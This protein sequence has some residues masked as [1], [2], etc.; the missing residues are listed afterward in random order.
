MANTVFKLRR[1]SVAGKVPNT[2]TVAIGELAINL[3]DKKLFSSDGSL[4]FEIGANLTDLQV[5]NNITTSNINVTD[6][7]LFQNVAVFHD[8]AM[9][10][11]VSANNSNGASGLVLTSN[12]SGVYWAPAG[13][14]ATGPVRQQFTGDGNTTTFAISGGYES[15]TVSVF[16]NGVML[17][18]GLEANVQSGVNVVISPAPANGALIDVVGY[19]VITSTSYLTIGNTSIS[20]NVI[21]IG[22]SSVNTQIVPGN[23]YLN[24]STLVIGNTSSNITIDSTTISIAGATINTSS[25]SGTANNTLYVGSVAS[26]D[27]VS[28]T[29]L[30]A[31]L[32]VIRSD[33]AN[34]YSNSVNYTSFAIG[35]AN[36]AMVA[37]ADAA[38]SNATSYTDSKIATANSAI[39]ANASAAYSNSVSYTDTKIATANLAIANAYSN[40]VS[41]TDAQIGIANS[42][43][44]SNA[45]AAYSNAVSYTDTKIA[46]ANL[47]IANAYS[48]AVSYTDSKIAT[49][50]L[51]IANAY[52]NAVSYTDSKIATANSEM[53]ANVSAAYSN[54]VSYTDSKIAT[55]NSAIV[56]NAAAAYSNATSYTDSKISTANSAIVANASAAYSNSVT[57]TDTKIGTA[58][59]AMVSNAATAY[60][61]SVTYTDSKIATANAAITANASAAYSNAT[62]YSSNASN[63][64]DGTLAEARLPYRMNQNVRN[65]DTVQFNGMTLTGNLVVSG[66]VNI[67]GANNL[68]LVDNMIYLNANS[69]VTNPDLGIAGNYNDGT[70]RHTGFFRDATDGF[71]KVFDNYGPEPD[72][73]PYIDTS[74]STFRIAN[75]WANTIYV[76]NTSVYATVNTTNFTGTANNSSYLGGTTAAS[77]ALKADTQYIGTTAVTLNRA[78]ASLA[79]TG[80]SIDG[81]AGSIAG[82]N[83]PPTNTGGTWPHL[84]KVN[85]DGAVEIGRYL[86]FHNGS[87]DGID[88]AVRLETGGTTTGLTLNGNQVITAGNY[89]SYALPLSGGTMTGKITFSTSGQQILYNTK[90]LLWFNNDYASWGYNASKNFFGPPI[91]TSA[92]YDSD[93]TAYYVDA[94]GTSNLNGLTVV[95][96]ITGTANNASNLGGISKTQIFNNMGNNHSTYTDFNNISDFG[97]RYVQGSTNGPGTG[98]SQFYGMT[99]GLGNEY[100]FSS[101]AYQIAFPRFVDNDKYISIRNREG[102]TWSSWT[103]IAAGVADAP[104]GS[105]FTASGSLRAPIFYDSDNTGYYIDPASGSNINTMSMAG[106]LSFGINSGYGINLYGGN[107]GAHRIYLDSY[108]TI[109]K[110]H[111]NEGWKFRDNSNTDRV[112][113]YGATGQ[114]RIAANPSGWSAAPGLVVGYNGDGYLQ[115]RHIWGKNPSDTGNDTLYLNY[116][117]G[118]GVWLQGTVNVNGTGAAS[119]DFRAPIFYDSDNTGYY[120]DPNNTSFLNYLNV[121]YSGISTLRPSGNWENPNF[122]ALGANYVYY[123]YIGGGSNLPSS[124]GYPYGTFWDIFPGGAGG[125]QFYVSHAGNDLCFRG[126][127]GNQAGFQTWNRVL[128]DQI[129]SSYCNFGGNAVYGGVYY[130]GNDTGYYCNPNETSNLIRWTV[131]TTNTNNAS[132]GGSMGNE[133]KMWPG[134]SGCAG[135]SFHR[136]GAYAV[137]MALD[138]DNIIRIGGWSAAANR[139]QMDMS[140]NL[141]MAGNVTAY[142]DIRLKENIELIKNALD[143]VKQIRGVTFTRNDQEDKTKRHTGIIAQEVERVLPEVVTEDNEGIKNVAYGNMAGLLI[144]AI[145]EQQEMIENM[146]QEMSDLKKLINS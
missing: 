63:I 121:G 141:T 127:W 20:G 68:S 47:E 135:F 8:V 16:L 95:G 25:F 71:W 94:A 41:Y 131:Y 60:S 64:S 14:S 42:S 129:Y 37:N 96:T 17:H 92:V 69:T 93:N 117:S 98:S 58:N 108:W 53:A 12:G 84:V 21:S 24:G 81:A 116:A 103:K 3:T 33:I 90:E 99:L 70:Y 59:S 115:T 44:T 45:S 57:Y 56:A 35:T 118:Y 18:N 113:I 87:A 112:Q 2:S 7:A 34:S 48:N 61:N 130:D 128:T 111:S 101:Y 11:A 54:A 52:S 105:I 107:T 109:F 10:G 139:L 136:Q 79:L 88:Y 55:A 89:S 83:N 9:L 43:I 39:V 72:A 32:T 74:N 27:V 97:F 5:S 30:Q 78:S 140:G 29:S 13:G 62:T 124:Y 110:S 31:N 146:K 76:G 145:K 120:V 143:K 28:N 114:I 67:I 132:Y 66:N 102:G 142:S 65:T 49:A 125:A 36:L 133:F 50:N 23:V 75:F 144:E 1:S 86:D 77:Y 137:N 40:A 126:H 106:D 19:S 85:T 73:S 119:A 4:V 123:G 38:Y 138:N 100:A 104:S 6:T 122:N 46:T 82:L 26:N 51:A 80:V 91:H 22:N 15:N 134:G